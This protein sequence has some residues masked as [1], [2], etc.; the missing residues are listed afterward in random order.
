[1]R[2]TGIERKYLLQLVPGI[3]LPNAKGAASKQHGHTRIPAAGRVSRASHKV[4]CCRRGEMYSPHRALQP[5]SHFS[6]T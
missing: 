5:K 6:L 4:L 2:S 3:K 1:M